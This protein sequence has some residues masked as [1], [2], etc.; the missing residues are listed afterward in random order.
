M[1]ST[2]DDARLIAAV[3]LL[4]DALRQARDALNEYGWG[5]EADQAIIAADEALD[6]VSDVTALT[7]RAD[8]MIDSCEWQSAEIKA[9]LD[10]ES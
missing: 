4:V 5:L 7:A 1:T 6:A 8:R 3:P 10:G 9:L 2:R